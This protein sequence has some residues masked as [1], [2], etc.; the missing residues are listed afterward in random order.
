MCFFFTCFSEWITCCSQVFVALL[1]GLKV[2]QTVTKLQLSNA[3]KKRTTLRKG[4]IKRNVYTDSLVSGF[5]IIQLRCNNQ[6]DCTTKEENHS[7]S[8]KVSHYCP[9]SETVRCSRWCRSNAGGNDTTC[10]E[11][12]LA[13]KWNVE[14]ASGNSFISRSGRLLSK[15]KRKR[16]Q[17]DSSFSYISLSHSTWTHLNFTYLMT[18]HST[19]INDRVYVLKA[20]IVHA[21]LYV[22]PA[23]LK[24]K[25]Q[26]YKQAQSNDTSVGFSPPSRVL[27]NNFPVMH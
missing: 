10:W 7:L 18:N 25:P 15:K 6:S 24:N 14:I 12:T 27:F 21:D 2:A 19:T 26:K 11:H 13:R 16:M 20:T 5:T 8:S 22:Y 23:R 3:S 9:E 4:G 17:S 1:K